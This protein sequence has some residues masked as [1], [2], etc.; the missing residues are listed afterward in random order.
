MTPN[1]DDLLIEDL[2]NKIFMKFDVN[3]SGY[4]D[5]REVLAMLDEILLS[6]NRPKTTIP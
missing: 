5:K 4:L 2:T 1:R 3:R 6:K